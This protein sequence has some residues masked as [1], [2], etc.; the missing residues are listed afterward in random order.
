VGECFEKTI[1]YKGH[2]AMIRTLY[3]FGFFS[4]KKRKI[5]KL[6][7]APRQIATALFL[8]NFVDDAPEAT[9]LRVEAHAK[10]AVASF[11]LVDK[12][13]TRTKLTSMMRTT[14]WPASVVL[15]MMVSGEINKRGDVLQERDVPAERFLKE[16]A[17][18]GLEIAYNIDGAGSQT[19]GAGA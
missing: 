16:M 5:G 7:I 10:D 2:C 8:E 6:E 13:D 3:D 12:T 4:S 17:A 1:R 19:A 9:I 15:Q 14:A 11:T 18:R